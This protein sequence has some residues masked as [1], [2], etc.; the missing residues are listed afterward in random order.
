MSSLSVGRSR[1]AHAPHTS[2]SAGRLPAWPYTA[3]FVGFPVW[4]LLGIVDFIWIPMAAV[5]ALYMVRARVVLTPRGFGI[6]LLFLVWAACSAASLTGPGQLIVFGYRYLVYLS[7][8]ILFIYIY[9]SRKTLTDRFVTGVLTV[10]WLFTVLGGYLAILFPTAVFRTPMSF[11]LPGA[12]V[13]NEW[14][15]HMVVRRLNQYNPD[16]V[17]ELDPRPSAPFLYTN[18]WGNV[19]SLLLPFVIAYLFQVRGTK[20]FWYVA[21]AIPVS[22]VPAVATLNRGMFLGIGIAMVYVALRM[23]LRR[24]PRG[25]L[26]LLVVGCIGVGLF[27]VLP[28]AERIQERSESG[29][30][31]DRASLYVQSF[32][33]VRESPLLGYG[34][35]LEPENPDLDPVGT[36]GQFWMILVSHGFGG[37]ICFLGW[38]IVA[39]VLSL[40]RVDLIGLTANTVLFVGTIELAYYG[41]IPYGLPILMIAAAIALRGP[42]DLPTPKH[43]AVQTRSRYPASYAQHRSH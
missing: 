43:V 3:A 27:Q 7:C 37:A 36:Q 6:W 29:S 1:R 19:Y 14:I 25:L 22:F 42:V 31:A 18:N 28:T 20:R 26:A 35:T 21:T 38:F 2:Q 33:A 13:N 30:T 41:S 16:S 32:S 10:W 23:L 17:F 24:D 8:T 9:N 34:R 4:W 40:R 11:V 39:F 15:N 5:M 12:L